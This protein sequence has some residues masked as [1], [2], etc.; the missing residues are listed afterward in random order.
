MEI[1]VAQYFD[2]WI[3]ATFKAENIRNYLL[4]HERKANCIARICEQIRIAEL[5]NIRQRFDVWRYRQVVE[6]CA[7]M[8]ADAALR[9]A[10]EQAISNA[11]RARRIDEASAMDNIKAEF[12]E[13][14]KEVLSGKLISRPG[15][16]AN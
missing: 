9:F 4:R 2:S 1:Q 5:S 3:I 14:E 10:E 16:T 12:D 7:K 8:F 13:M 15:A 6:A 11:E